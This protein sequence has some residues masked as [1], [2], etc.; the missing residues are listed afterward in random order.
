MLIALVSIF[1]ANQLTEFRNDRLPAREATTAVTFQ[2]LLGETT[3][4]GRLTRL[5]NAESVAIDVNSARLAERLHPLAPWEL[6]AIVAD[7]R[8]FQLI[9][10]GRGG[11]DE[12]ATRA[13]NALL[14]TFVEQEPFTGILGIQ[15]QL[16]S[17]V[18]EIIEVERKIAEAVAAEPPPEPTEADY[19]AAIDLAALDAQIA[20]LTAQHNLLKIELINPI[21]ANPVAVPRSSA[22]IQADIDQVV[23]LLTGLQIERQA[24]ADAIE[25][26]GGTNRS[27]SCRN[28]RGGR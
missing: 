2:R 27:R 26:A 16:D 1:I 5:A 28:A 18:N 11:T 10:T 4:E 3:D 7:E 17:L 23:L 8:T 13:V 19:V 25:E 20:A 14:A 12:E 22:E 21:P 6:A 9:F 24:K 15:E